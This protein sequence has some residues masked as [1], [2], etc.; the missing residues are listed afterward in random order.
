MTRPATSPPVRG[1]ASDPRTGG[2]A[3][4]SRVQ[5]VDVDIRFDDFCAVEGAS[6]DIAAGEFV[7]L[8]G[9]SGCGKSTLL[10]AIAGFVR[11]AAGQVT[12]ADAPVTGPDVD[13]G[14]VF[15]SA[16]A[17]FPWLTVRQNV[18]FGPKMRGVSRTHRAQIA[19]RYLTM[20]GLSH[21]GDRFPGQLSGGMRQRAQLARVLANEPSVVLMDEPFGALDAQTRLVMQTELD[22]IWRATR[23]T[24][25]FVTHDIGEAILLADRIVTMTAGPAARIKQVYPVDLPRPRDLTDPA[26]AG[27]FRRLRADIGAEVA[28]TLR[29][30]GLDDGHGLSGG[31]D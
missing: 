2:A 16:E 9:P 15:Q 20:V 23:S 7:C 13:R 18:A 10:N 11:P 31:G 27:L 8:L 28:R 1:S 29:A 5:V 19:D 21:S 22:R 4:G 25:L 26:A 24:I 30:Q 6:L 3:G 12:C 17:L 14:V